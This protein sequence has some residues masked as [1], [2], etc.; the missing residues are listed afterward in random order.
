VSQAARYLV[1]GGT[2]FLGS[3]SPMLL[4]VLCIGGFALMQRGRGKAHFATTVGAPVSATRF[5]DVAGMEEV[6]E[7]L[8]E[9]VEFLKDPKRFGRLG[10]RAPRGAA[11]A[12]WHRRPN[13]SQRALADQARGARGRE[14]LVRRYCAVAGSARERSG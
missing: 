11:E 3:A 12:G 9:T 8:K 4:L 2:G 14:G 6:K 1:T 10:A 13:R 7:S 5:E